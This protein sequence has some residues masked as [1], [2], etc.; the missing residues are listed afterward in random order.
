MTTNHRPYIGAGNATQ[1]IHLPANIAGYLY[2]S[3]LGQ[4]I[5]VWA[6]YHLLR[7]V[8]SHISQ[9]KQNNWVQ[10]PPWDTLTE[11]VLLT[12]GSSGIGNQVMRDL[13]RLHI[14]T[15]IL[16]VQEPKQ[17]L[18]DNIFFYNVGLT[19]S[20]AI[21]ETATQV[22]RD[23]GSPTILIN[24]AGVGSVG[25]ILEEP[26]ENIRRTLEVNMVSHFWT[27]KELL[28]DMVKS[29]HGHIVSIASMASFAGLNG[30]ADYACTKA[31]AL[32]FQESLSQEIRHLY[33]ARRIRTSI[34]HPMWVHTPMLDS[35]LSSGAQFKSPTLAP[36]SVSAA[37]IRQLMRGNGGQVIIPASLGFA[38]MLRGLPNWLQEVMRDRSSRQ[39][40]S[41]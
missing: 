19:S 13:S 10:A 6:I 28:P 15:V 33:G 18:P 40:T 8:N 37:I 20:T 34:I 24:N 27:V 3:F 38:S 4:A 23:H 39:L 21:A 25:S 16:D 17:P 11:L 9:R 36:E 14:K 35:L 32:E 41:L 29:Y 2:R 12:G 1:L 30:M 31:G 22:R 5:S 26:E 7:V